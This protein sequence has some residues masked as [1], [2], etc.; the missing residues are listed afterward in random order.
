MSFCARILL[1][2][3]LATLALANPA[4]VRVGGYVFPPFVEVSSEGEWTGVTLDLI[5]RLN[6]MQSEYHFEFVPTAAARRYRELETGHFD[7]LFFENPAWG[8]QGQD[9]Q[10]I[11]GVVLSRAL[12]IA[13]AEDS[14]TQDYFD[15]R[16]GKRI[17]LFSGYH[18]AFAG[19][20]ADPNHLRDV[21]NAVLTLSQ[22]SNIQMV[23]RGRVDMAVV[24]ESFLEA[25]LSR[26]PH[27]RSRLLIAEEADQYYQHFLLMRSGAEPGLAQMKAYVDQLQD[28]GA[29]GLILEHNGINQT[30]P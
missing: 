13:L 19:F 15:D 17:A 6:A 12:F 22:E 11:D 4:T 5:D 9:T 7:M 24:T 26:H 3:S 29:L 14:R 20:I 18:Y 23:L 21:H 30:Q 16:Q 27:Y 1:L 2:W 25:Y 8:W 10:S 28:S